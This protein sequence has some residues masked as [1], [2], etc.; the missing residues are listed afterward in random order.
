MASIKPYQLKS[1]A[2]RYEV[3]VSNGINPGTGRQNKIHKSGFKSYD[4]ASSWAK[5]KEGEIASG[6]YVRENPEKMTIE[7]YLKEWITNYKGDVKEGTRIVY[8]SMMDSYIIPEVGKYPLEKY[9]HASHQKFINKMASKKGTGRGEEDG[10]AENTLKSINQTISAAFKTAV[11]SLGY[12]KS[13]PAKG[14]LFPKKSKKEQHLRYLSLKDSEAFLT[15]TKKERDVLWFPFFLLVFD[16]G[17]RKSEA[18]G[19]Q[20]KYIDFSNDLVKVRKI[21]LGAAEK[22]ENLGKMVIDDPKTPKSVRDIPMTQRTKNALLTYR[23]QILSLFGT[24]PTTNDGEEFVFIQTKNK[25]GK[26]LGYKTPNDVM[27]RILKKCDLPHVCVHE[28]RHTF[29]VRLRQAGVSLENIADLLG[30]SDTKTTQIYA[31]ITPEV[32]QDSIQ[33]LEIYLDQQINE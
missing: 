18:L 19:M 11:N 30:H 33:K 2:K 5:I 28:G 10:L 12:V 1:G 23:N 7:Q 17:L 22:G 16:C 20:W 27:S 21:R 3:Y 13:N 26:F 6:D 24:L 31:E 29:A 4:E 14:T 8:Q 15:A 32:K 9:T 25:P